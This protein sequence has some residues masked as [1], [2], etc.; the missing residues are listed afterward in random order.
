MLLCFSMFLD[1]YYHV[2]IPNGQ[3]NNKT[4]FYWGKIYTPST[5]RAFHYELHRFPINGPQC[6]VPLL[7]LKI[8]LRQ[9]LKNRLKSLPF[10]SIVQWSQFT[11]HNYKTIILDLKLKGIWRA[12]FGSIALCCKNMAIWIFSQFCTSSRYK[13]KW[14]S[15]FKHVHACS[16]LLRG[17]RYIIWHIWTCHTVTRPTYG[18]RPQWVQ[19]RCN[20][21][22]IDL[23]KIVFGSNPNQGDT[24]GVISCKSS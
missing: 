6:G 18:P 13:R 2:F 10:L 23:V 1:N 12:W 19:Y 5:T 4:N 21:I 22:K 9:S 20:S 7:Q 24:I 8:Y 3:S 11:T 14:S 17:V 15:T 16:L